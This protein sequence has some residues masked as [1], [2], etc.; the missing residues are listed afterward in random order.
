MKAIAFGIGIIA[1]AA[2]VTKP[3]VAGVTNF[4]RV[5]ATMACA[6]ATTPEG[7][8]A[9]KQ[10]GYA[11]VINL[12]Q[13]SETGANLDAEAEAARA[14][15]LRYVHLPLNGT[16]P[17]PDVVAQFLQVVTDPANQP[18]LVHCSSGNRAAALWMI[19]R[20]VVDGWDEERATKEAEE[21]GLT[22]P[23]LKVFAIDYAASHRK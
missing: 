8:A 23:A 3:P 11:T 15:G 16:A 21:L 7:I 19:K 9:I 22:S 5:D 6:G 4:A 1:L 18:V 17:D 12:R 13:A 20:L 10:L 2:Q 14:A